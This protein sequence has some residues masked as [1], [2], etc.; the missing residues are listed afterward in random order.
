[1][2]QRSLGRGELDDAEREGDDGSQSMKRDSRRGIEQ[3]RK[4][5]D[6][7]SGIS[8]QALRSEYPWRERLM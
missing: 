1:V 3:R 7:P 4:A 5:H 8:D 6:G 2:R